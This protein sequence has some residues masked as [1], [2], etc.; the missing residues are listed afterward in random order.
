MKSVFLYTNFRDFL[1]DEFEQ[2]V[3][4]NTK[5]SLRA[6]SRDVGI[7]F[8]RLSEILSSEEGISTATAHKI[9]TGLKMVDAEREYFLQ[10]VLSQHGR[11]A[12]IRTNAL[13]KVKNFKAKKKFILIKENYSGILSNWYYIA[14]IELLVL[15]QTP[16]INEISKILKIS[17][18]EVEAAISHL[19]VLGYISRLNQGRWKKS[20]EFLKVESKSP[21]KVIKE[22]HAVFLNRAKELGLH[23]PIENRKH[24]SSIFGVKKEKIEEARRELEKFNQEFLEKFASEGDA[25]M[26]YALGLQLFR[27]SE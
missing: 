24:L 15:K 11:T 23:Q 25:D 27:I 14:L 4:R 8:S 10:L 7:S 19:S 21:S 22:Y 12:Y 2:R 6:F 26:V 18:E 9:A 3:L 16:D 1:K 13:N 20:S 17:K 5:Y